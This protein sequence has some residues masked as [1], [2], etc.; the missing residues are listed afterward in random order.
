MIGP[1]IKFQSKE[2]S[3]RILKSARREDGGGGVGELVHRKLIG[4]GKRMQCNFS[5]Q[6]ILFFGTYKMPGTVPTTKEGSWSYGNENNQGKD[7]FPEIFSDFQ[8]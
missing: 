7:L 8:Q 4:K 6:Y 5:S 2:G 3:K 1:E